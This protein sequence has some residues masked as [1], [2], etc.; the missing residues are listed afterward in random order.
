MKA[1]KPVYIILFFIIIYLV[2][3]V[4][5]SLPGYRELFQELTPANLL[6]AAVILFSFHKNRN[7]RHIIAFVLVFVLGFMVELAGV[8][9]GLVF[10]SYHYGET[11]GPKLM[12]TPLI[13]GVNWLML[14]Y[15]VFAITQKMNMNFFTQVIAGAFMLLM[16][17][18]VLEPVAIQ[19]DFWSWGGTGIPVQNYLAW[20]LISALFIGIW[21]AMKVKTENTIALGLFIIQFS[22]FLILNFT[23]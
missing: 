11:L 21:R 9:T 4:G 8:H 19:L 16:Y 18:L 15:M 3:L 14:V 13:I 6:L 17:D 22:F 10:G 5:L 23:L 7:I 1:I 12:D 20:L 2:G